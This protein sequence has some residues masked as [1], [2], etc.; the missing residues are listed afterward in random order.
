MNSEKDVLSF[1]FA[2]QEP[3]DMY[4][5]QRLKYSVQSQAD[6]RTKNSRKGLCN[7]KTSDWNKAHYCHLQQC[8]LC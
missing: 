7:S 4:I 3:S 6:R 5:Y 1:S 8:V 2:S